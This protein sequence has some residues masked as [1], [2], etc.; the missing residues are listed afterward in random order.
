[1][2][3]DK[4]I[5]YILTSEFLFTLLPI[6]ILLIVRSYESNFSAIFYNTEWS[7]IALI[8]F[9]QSIVKFSSGI[10][11]SKEKFRWQLV[12]LVISI[13][14]IFGLIPSAIILVLNLS[15]KT[16]SNGTYI[17]QII[18]FIISSLTFFIVGA[19]GQKMLDE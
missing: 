10:T 9:G 14:I 12:A 18:L 6:I 4:T 11:N 17:A 7:I 5:K 1:M 3:I 2:K 16:L 13:I 19:L 8:L 15:S